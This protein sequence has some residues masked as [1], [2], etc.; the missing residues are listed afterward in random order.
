MVLSDLAIRRPVFATVVSLVLVVFGIAAYLRLTV[1]EFPDI[2]PPIVSINTTYR[3]APARVVESKVTQVIEDAIAGIAGIR[4]ISASS[5]EESS[6]L[7]IEFTLHVNVDA[8]TNDV[9]DRVSRIV[10][11]LPPGTDPPVVAKTEADAQ[12]ILW[13]VLSSERLEPLE[14]TDLAERVIVDRLSNVPGVAS[15]MLGGHRRYAMRVWLDKRA[16]AARGITVQE[17]EAAIRRQNV[18]LPS[19]RIESTER[20]FT[21]RA[22]SALRTPEQ[23]R[24]ITIRQVGDYPVRLGEVARVEL[25]AENERTLLRVNGK[26]GLGLGIVKQSKANTLD[27][28]NLAKQEAQRLLPSLPP[29]TALVPSHD[30]SIFVSQS[31]IEVQHALAI[32]MALVIGIIFVFLR[33]LRATLIPAVAIPVSVIASFMV[34]AAL[35]YSINVLTLLALVLSIG[36][37][38]DDAIVVLENVHRRIEEGEPTLLAAVRGSRQIGFAVIST[39][40]TLVAVFVPLS[41]MQGATGRL[42]REFGVSVAAAVLFSALVAL[43]LTPMM[44]SRL[45]KPITEEGGL[46]RLSQGVFDGMNHGYRW[47]LRHA[48]GVPVVVVALAVAISVLAWGLFRSLPQE[49][50]PVEDRGVFWASVYAPQGSSMDFTDRYTKQVEEV[51]WPLLDQGASRVMAVIAPQWG[52]VSPVNTAFIVVRLKHW[53]ERQM[54]QQAMLKQVVPKLEKITGVTAHASN[55]PSLGGIGSGQPVVMVIGGS[56]YKS[57]REQAERIKRRVEVENPRLLNLGYNYDTTRPIIGVDINRGRAA[58]LGVSVEDVGRSLETLLGSREV[59]Q[60]ARGGKQ[61]KVLL[62]AE[63]RDRHNPRDL[64]DIYVKSQTTG[65]LVPLAN[66]VTLRETADAP[67]LPRVDRLRALTLTASLAPDYPLGDALHYMARVVAEELPSEVRV[68]YAGQSREFKESTGSLF[69]VFGM[70]LCIVFLVLAAQ[71]ESWIHPLIIML[72][73]PLAV[74]GAL[75]AMLWSGLTIN[76]YT[77]IGLIML[78]G[79]VA[80][81]AILIVEFANQ[82]R[83][84]GRE[85]GEAVLEASVTRLRPILMTSIATVLGAVPLALATGAGAEARAALGIV[86]IGGLCFSTVLSLFVVPVLYLALARFAKPAGTIER[87][88]SDLD[89]AHAQPA[90]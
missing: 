61:Y 81:N 41:F 18:E 28:A 32:A 42:F 20:E 5:R 86:I 4:T 36:L 8:A 39:T 49:L 43:T 19:G 27:V 63:A 40:L 83:E 69:I 23:F 64:N 68:S 16:M 37:V 65:R 22:D 78:I 73:V 44:C 60:F 29:G 2:D 88:L 72:S 15:V 46:Y 66:L 87:L 31:I 45:L 3:G 55:P 13:L 70:A 6:Q 85:V 53:S 10:K 25:G 75:G 47:L 52:G 7:S 67:S 11:D 1:R 50:A 26:A 33:S 62:Q 12:P 84:A 38:V 14:L 79:L 56:D 54:S 48:L 89:R 59:T 35:G 51:L 77:Q 82:L 71:F 24:D 17:I 58:D 76:V 30:S 90:E 21:V 57:L 9:R 80:K 74:T 34:L